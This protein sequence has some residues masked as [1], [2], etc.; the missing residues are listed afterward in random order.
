M[1]EKKKRGGNNDKLYDMVT[2][3]ERGQIVIPAQ[4][5]KDFGLQSGDRLMVVKG[6]VNGTMILVDTKH[7]T[8]AFS[9][10]LNSISRMKNIAEK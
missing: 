10:L 9:Q 7:M 2:L 1:A 6:L 4:A 5:R 3:G 8:Q